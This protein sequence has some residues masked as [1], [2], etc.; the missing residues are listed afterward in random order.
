[1]HSC[2]NFFQGVYLRPEMKFEPTIKKFCLHYFSLRT[3]WND[4]SFRGGPK[5]TAHSA[6]ANHPCFYEINTYADVFFHDFISGTVYMIFY[7]RNEISFLS[8][9]P[10]WN[11]THSK[12]HFEV[13]HV[14]RRNWPDTVYNENISFRLR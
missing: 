8:Q 11:N 3:K 4:I 12:F 7:H 9:W 10:Q 1:M 5:K 14:N 6:K 2:R 13:F